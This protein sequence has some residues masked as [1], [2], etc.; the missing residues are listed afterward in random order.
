MLESGL[1]ALLRLAS[2]SPRRRQLLSLAGIPF[3]VTPV[4]IDESSLPGETPPDYVLRL[5]Q[6]KARA[7]L[8]SAGPEEIILTA[9][10]TVADGNRILGKPSGPEDARKM[11]LDLR[12]RA[13][14]VYTAVGVADSSTARVVT[15]LC[16]TTVWMRE[17]SLAEV[18]AYIA[19]GDP[20]DKAGAYAI[21]HQDFHPVERI[22]GCYACVMGLPLCHVLRALGEF[23]LRSGADVAAACPETLAIDS[24]CPLTARIVESLLGETS[25]D[26]TEEL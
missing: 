25:P 6:E 14:M 21:Q 5:A 11:L 8:V 1:M 22:E 10:T 16:A 13:H 19:S 23:G 15:D 12:G 4:D 20:F 7:A 18:E 3:S 17:Y 26:G 24:P 2:N 9:D